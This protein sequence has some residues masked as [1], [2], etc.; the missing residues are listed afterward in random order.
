MR[1]S[2]RAIIG[3]AVVIVLLSS[4]ASIFAQSNASHTV[5]VGDSLDK[6][7]AIYDVEATCLGK[8]NDI[9][10]GDILKP[11]QVLTIDFSCPRY[12]G[13]DFVQNP[14]ELNSNVSESLGQGGGGGAA[15]AG[16][17]VERGDTLDTIGQALNV[18]VVAIQVANDIPRGGIIQPGQSLIIPADAPPYGQFPALTVPGNPDSANNELGQGGGGAPDLSAGDTTYVVQQQET[19]DGIGARFDVKVACLASENDIANA[20]EIYPGQV[21]AIKTSCPRYDGF[22][23]VTNPR[24]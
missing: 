22:D 20:S 18:S 15:D 19:L 21:L 6:I 10:G 1:L 2:V 12:D 13:V 11:G 3:L 17:I 5:E 14:R 23:F 8:A 4:T 16:Y 7:G 24:G 9:K